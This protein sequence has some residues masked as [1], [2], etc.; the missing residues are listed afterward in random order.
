MGFQEE[1]SWPNTTC[2][3][4]T[5]TRSHSRAS[6]LSNRQLLLFSLQCQCVCLC[7]SACFFIYSC[8]CAGFFCLAV[9]KHSQ[10]PAMTYVSTNEWVQSTN[11]MWPMRGTAAQQQW[12]K[13][14]ETNSL[15]NNQELRGDV[16]PYLG[17]HFIATVK[18][19][20]RIA[21]S[22]HQPSPGWPSW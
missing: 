19:M 5:H 21:T 6:Q 16:G 20:E 14:C 9:W 18:S 7:L 1:K 13:S 11:R 15:L 22:S 2:P 4:H 8:V 10:H 17:L 3:I 12:P